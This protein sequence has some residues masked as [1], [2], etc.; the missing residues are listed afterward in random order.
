MTTRPRFIDCSAL[1]PLRR[2]YFDLGLALCERDR[3]AESVA[4]FVNASKEPGDDPASWQIHHAKGVAYHSQGEDQAA[5]LA[6]LESVAD[7]PD[8]ASDL[9][10]DAHDVLTQRTAIAH[11]KSLDDWARRIPYSALRGEDRAEVAFFLGRVNLYTGDNS[12]AVDYFREAEKLRPG[13]TRILEGLGSC[14]LKQGNLDAALEAFKQARELA[15]QGAYHKRLPTI[16]AKLV[17]I[18]IEKGEY[19]SA[20]EHAVESRVEGSPYIHELLLAEGLSHLA[21]GEPERA[22]EIVREPLLQNSA[23]VDALLLRAQALIAKQE[24]RDAI[25]TIN[26]ALQ[27]E[28]GNPGLAFHKIQALV[29][30]DIDLDQAQRLLKDYMEDENSAEFEEFKA[31]LESPLLTIRASESNVVYFLARVHYELCE[32]YPKWTREQALADVERALSLGFVDKEENPEAAAWLLKGQILK[33]QQQ[34]PSAAQAYYEAGRRYGWRHEYQRAAEP[35]RLSNDLDPE[36]V[37]TYWDLSENLRLLANQAEGKEE[38][39]KRLLK[40]LDIWQSGDK[41]QRRDRSA[42][43]S[44]THSWALISRALLSEDLAI[45]QAV[46]PAD[47]PSYWWEALVFIERALLLDT[48]YA[49]RWTYYLGCY[50]RKLK[51]ESNALAASDA[52]LAEDENNLS[53]QEERLICL[54]N[55]GRFPEALAL[56]RNWPTGG[57]TI[58]LKWLPL[59]EADML[60]RSGDY[61]RAL[62]ISGGDKPNDQDLWLERKW[63]WAYH[64]RAQCY[65]MLG[66]PDQVLKAHLAIWKKFQAV[67]VADILTFGQSA[68]HIAMLDREQ[69]NLIHQAIA[70]AK[71]AAEDPSQAMGA[72]SLLG[73]CYL[74][75]EET[76][77]AA[78]DELSEAIRLATNRRELQDLVHLDFDIIRTYTAQWHHGAA[79]R[80]ILKELEVHAANKAEKLHQQ[81]QPPDMELS[82]RMAQLDNTDGWAWWAA[83]AGLARLYAEQKRWREAAGAYQSLLEKSDQS[84]NIQAPFPEARLGLEKAV[85]ELHA[86]GKYQ[87]DQKNAHGATQW[88]EQALMFEPALSRPGKFA[89]M[90]RELGDANLQADEPEEALKQYTKALDERSV[91]EDKQLQAGMYGRMGY[92]YFGMAD[93]TK[94]RMSFSEALRLFRE[95]EVL[96]PGEAL[97]NIC[98]SR[99]LDVRRYWDLDSEWQAFAGDALT[100]ETLRQDLTA[101]RKSLRVYLGEVFQLGPSPASDYEMLPVVTPIAVEMGKDLLPMDSGPEWPLLKVYLPEMRERL[102]REMGVD[103]PGVRVRGIED[104][105]PFDGYTIL[106]NEVPVA[107]GTLKPGQ[108]YCM[109]DPL[110]LQS[111]CTIPRSDLSESGDPATGTPGC[112]LSSEYKPLLIE[113][114]LNFWLDHELYMIHHIEAIL[115]QNLDSF[116]GVQET[117]KLLEQ[118]ADE[119]GRSKLVAE[120]VPDTTTQLRL[121]R[122]LRALLAEG[123]SIAPW[124]KILEVVREAGLPHEDVHETVRAVRLHLKEHL[125]GNP[126]KLRGM[127]RVPAPESFELGVSKGIVLQ[128]GTPFLDIRPEET[129]ELM[130][131]IRSVL[132]DYGQDVVLVV[133]DAMVRPFVRRLVALE[134]PRVYVMAEEELLLEDEEA[135]EE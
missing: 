96:D 120:A 67:E 118:W 70:M 52:T 90:L 4:A 76:I 101:A 36:Q 132:Q 119:D 63:Y 66:Q 89:E 129:Q 41:L 115:R 47:L 42:L 94:A 73:F 37:P 40:S 51:L 7:A 58:Y 48:D 93:L 39:K 1:P 46:K 135:V 102:K 17:R 81:P 127:T 28:P 6:F 131:E 88:L 60:A 95:A 45:V 35:L 86:E 9:L 19:R 97:G 82:E 134:F 124:R 77:A 5:L 30:G 57:D 116:V 2:L 26:E 75:A 133:H 32:L 20:L 56:I 43:H 54:T 14:L 121:G 84:S 65:A 71:E 11:A 72:H 61:L 53:A 108:V 49:N 22:L 104:T 100:G 106:L 111:L 80:Q 113:H 25:S 109:E 24:Y 31:R 112:W 103:V 50:Y 92:V 78:R 117:A 128:D 87:L 33:D 12:K 18:L 16:G 114:R 34:H 107:K 98:K 83:M 27:Y 68:F 79:A 126:D 21:L 38:R 29:E 3:H 125:F 122:V 74:A 44:S 105:P 110:I 62:E 8:K 91:A 130:N 15:R 23:D 69:A 55:T 10:R 64:F 99:L 85:D 123:V 59:V 13:E